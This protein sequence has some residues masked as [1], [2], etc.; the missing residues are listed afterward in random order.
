TLTVLP[1]WTPT[2][3][4][5]ETLDTPTP[6][7]TPIFSTN[8][9]ILVAG[10]WNTSLNAGE[11]GNF[12]LV[13]LSGFYLEKELQQLSD[14]GWLLRMDLYSGE[15]NCLIDPAVVAWRDPDADGNGMI[16][17]HWGG[18]EHPILVYTPPQ[19]PK[20]YLLGLKVSAKDG[21]G[22]SYSTNRWPYLTVNE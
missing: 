19:D 7:I 3:T 9:Q 8:P 5:T 1:T 18:A 21:Y 10:Y 6:T 16:E 20:R 12:Y 22:S 15:V 17:W 14:E 13:A 2:V 4:P 11:Y